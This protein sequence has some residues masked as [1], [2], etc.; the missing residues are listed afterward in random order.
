MKAAEKIPQ[1]KDF[2][3]DYASYMQAWSEI[4][5]AKQLHAERDYGGA[6]EHYEKAAEL[7]KATKRWNHLHQNYLAWSRLE[8]AE[9][10]SRREQ[11]EEA[12]DL[13]QEAAQL[14]A[15]AKKSVEAKLEGMETGEE[16]DMAARLTGASDK[17]REYCLGRTTLEEARILDRQGDHN[18]SFRKYGSAS[19]SFQKIIDSTEDESDRRELKPIACLC[20]A[21]EKMTRAEAEASPDLYLEASRLFDEAKEQTFDEKSKVLA[22][23][24]SRFCRAL[25]AGTRFEDTR[26]A[27]VYSGAKKH[28]EAATSYYLKA[29]FQN[30]SEYA[31]AT[32]RLFDAYAYMYQAQTEMDVGKKAQLYQ[33]AERLLQASAGSYIKAK[34]PEK[35]EQVRRL[36]ESVREEQQLAMSLTEVLHAPTI[37]SATASFSTPTATHEQAVGLER[38]EN[39]DIQAN[40]IPREQEAKIGEDISLEIELVNAGKAAA[41]LIKVEEILPEGFKLVEKPEAYRVEDSYL[42]MKGKSL[43]PLRTEEVKLV[44]RPL[45]KGTFQ[46]KPRILYLDEAGKYRSHE[47]EPATVV[48]KELGISGW[49][50]GPRR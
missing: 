25:E 50:K 3:Q 45:N 14:F 22:L 46:I 27:A 17:R 23:G 33:M 47:P 42:N 28:V 48:V 37:M 44:L 19:D 8:T 20:Q 15:E 32:Y 10:H 38:F 9:D 16:K 1:P 11:T 7:H 24:H 35:G 5:K 41:Q 26:D 36:L 13:F 4:E 12:R 43:A 2:Y 39:A 49:L 6:K 31:K 30:A 21:W 29:G 40:L 18:A 34:H